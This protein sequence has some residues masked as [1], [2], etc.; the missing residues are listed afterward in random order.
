MM[1]EH[2]NKTKDLINKSRRFIDDHIIPIEK[3]IH[4]E[5]Q[6]SKD[7]W[8]S[9]PMVEELKEKARKEGL[10]NLFLPE[11]DHGA[12]LSNLEYA[13]I[14]EITGPHDLA[15]EVF[16]CNAPDTGNMEVLVKYGTPAQKEQW[17][18]PLLAGEIRS[19]FAMTEPNVA[20][21]DATNMQAT[22]VMDGDKIVI[23]GRK[24][25]ISGFADPRCKI[26][27]FMG[28]TDPSAPRHQQHSMV[29]V[30]RDSKGV[31]FVRH[32]EVFGRLDEPHG[33]AE[34]KFNNVRVPRAN[35]LLG[36]GRGFEIAQ[37][38]LGPGR[39][40][41]CMRSIG[42]AEAALKM[43]VQRGTSKTAFGSRLIDLDGN[44]QKIAQ[45][46]IEIDQARLLTLKAAWM[47]DTHGVKAARSEI[48][49]IKVVAPT[50]TQ[51]VLDRAIQMHGAA[52]VSDDFPLARMWGWNRVLRIADGPDE[53]HLRTVAKQE[54]KKYE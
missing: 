5:R 43:M 16:N 49:Q 17:L 11:S 10:W 54:V 18:L 50:V 42:V 2:S 6:N 12:G 4:H 53:V 39:I 19:C 3:R 46:R 15:Q 30:P 35:F 29:L 25:Y 28:L 20:S 31:E 38:R 9:H 51:Q 22:A 8:V 27:I 44:R 37:G 34:I 24:W 14:A 47:M 1:F 23:N 45:S 52:G 21:S 36:P 7:P 13:P 48:A 41:H 33:H 26:I 32:M 40:H